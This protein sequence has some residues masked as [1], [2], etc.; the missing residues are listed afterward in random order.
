M[1]VDIASKFCKI[2][3]KLCHGYYNK[4]LRLDCSLAQN[5]CKTFLESANLLYVKLV[6]GCFSH[7]AIIAACMSD[8]L[9]WKE[10]I[11]TYFLQDLSS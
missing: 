8:H 6:Y 10:Y 11:Y 3:Y 9:Y 2:C 7:R 1:T 5:A 4:V